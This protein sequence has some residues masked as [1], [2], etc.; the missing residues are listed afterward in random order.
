MHLNTFLI[1]IFV[2]VVSSISS[3]LLGNL[4]WQ[5]NVSAPI[6]F[7]FIFSIFIFVSII[8]I[9]IIDKDINKEIEDN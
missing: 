1:Y 5:D 9:R 6:I 2:F 4:L 8:F 7:T 3:G